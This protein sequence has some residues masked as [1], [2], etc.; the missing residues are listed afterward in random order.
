[1]NQHVKKIIDQRSFVMDSWEEEI[2][3]INKCKREESKIQSRIGEIDRT[4]SKELDKKRQVILKELKNEQKQL[5]EEKR[6]EKKEKKEK[7]VR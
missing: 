1:M 3:K 7:K 2:D 4:V 6:K 5:Q